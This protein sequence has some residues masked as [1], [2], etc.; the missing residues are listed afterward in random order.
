[1]AALLSAYQGI[2]RDGEP[3][4]LK[5][6]LDRLALLAAEPAALTRLTG[7]ASPRVVGWLACSGAVPMQFAKSVGL[8]EV[9]VGGIADLLEYRA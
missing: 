9:R 4:K 1:M 7:I 3:D 5:R 6:H 8:S 2:E